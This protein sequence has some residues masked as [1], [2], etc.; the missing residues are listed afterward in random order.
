MMHRMATLGVLLGLLAM[1]CGGKVDDS[2]DGTSFVQPGEASPDAFFGQ[3][4]YK[5]EGSLEH[6]YPTT[7]THGKL[8]SDDAFR[9]DLFMQKDGRYTLRYVELEKKDTL[10][11][12]P[13]RE[14][15]VA[16]TW[17]VDG[18]QLVLDGLTRADAAVSASG[19]PA[20]RVRFPKD[21]G[22]PGLA[23]QEAL[24]EIRTS[25]HGLE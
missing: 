5:R 1:A 22:S 14:V 7:I 2:Q 6:R 9:A 19:V 25:P 8:A 4:V 23:N 11:L 16:G 18:S 3:F 10:T 24:L 20:L 17:R 21:I 13:V 15:L 12:A